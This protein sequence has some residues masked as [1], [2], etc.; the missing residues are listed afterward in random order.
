MP[1]CNGGDRGSKFAPDRK[2]SGLA[3]GLTREKPIKK[4][5]LNDKL[6]VKHKLGKRTKRATRG[7]ESD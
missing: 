7:R 2:E 6:D 1:S 5:E 4:T 3:L